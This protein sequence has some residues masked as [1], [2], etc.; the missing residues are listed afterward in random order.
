MKLSHTMLWLDE[1]NGDNT[2]MFLLAAKHCLHRTKDFS[3]SPA[4]VPV[5][6]LR[7]HKKLGEDTARTGPKGCPTP[8]SIMLNS[9]SW[10][11][12]GGR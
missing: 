3:A 5:R 8:C 2:L 4:A 1:N 11:K 9:N 10:G 12:E 6:S 7:V